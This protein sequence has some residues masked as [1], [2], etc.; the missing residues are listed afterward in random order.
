MVLTAAR[1]L[2][3]DEV[4]VRFSVKALDKLTKVW[5][6]VVMSEEKLPPLGN[7]AF[8]M[9][10]FTITRKMEF[11]APKANFIEMLREMADVLEEMDMDGSDI[12]TLTFTNNDRQKFVMQ[13]IEKRQ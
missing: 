2:G 5:Y 8:Y 9:K 13:L 4:R 7:R 12:S 1:I 10:G 3:M 6:N 11:E